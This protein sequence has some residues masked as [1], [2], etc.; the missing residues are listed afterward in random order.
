MATTPPLIRLL[1]KALKG[2]QVVQV[3]LPLPRQGAPCLRNGTSNLYGSST[4]DTPS[5]ARQ[6]HSPRRIGR[7]P[8]VLLQLQGMAGG[9]IVYPLQHMLAGN[10]RSRMFFKAIRA[11]SS[12]S[13]L[14]ELEDSNSVLRSS[15]N[16]LDRVCKD[17][18]QA[19]Y[20]KRVASPS[21]LENQ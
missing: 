9:G 1:W 6:C 17:F 21:V 8:G 16:D 7:H 20:T 5:H 11:R 15:S 2:R 3:S 18:Y 19:L 4:S 12:Q 13:T 14:M 10:W